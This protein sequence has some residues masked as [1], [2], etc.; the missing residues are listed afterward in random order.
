M[1]FRRLESFVP[2]MFSRA[3]PAPVQANP[4]E[5]A[6]LK[7]K[8]YSAGTTVGRTALG[9]IGN[10]GAKT[11]SQQK[12]HARPNTSAAATAHAVTSARDGAVVTRQ[13]VPTDSRVTAPSAG[14]F[15]EAAKSFSFV[16]RPENVADIDAGDI[17]NPQLVSEYVNECY[18]YMKELERRQNVQATYLSTQPRGEITPEMRRILIDW[19]VDVHVK[20]KLVQETMQMTVHVL[21]RFLQAVPVARRKLQLVGITCLLIASKYEDM[22][23]P[24]VADC[25]YVADNAYEAREVLQM[26]QLILRTL[27][28]NLG[29]PLALHFLRRYSK[30]SGTEPKVHTLAKYI[31]ELKMYEYGMAHIYP[32]ITAASALFLARRTLMSDMEWSST[33]E[34][35][36]GYNWKELSATVEDLE[37]VLA[38]AA[39]SKEQAVRRKFAAS[40][41]WRVS[42][43]EEIRDFTPVPRSHV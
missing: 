37:S 13:P 40:K 29:C 30:A 8:R 16:D 39:S 23:P 6:A 18:S 43:L 9:D 4:N 2:T 22:W 42:K 14:E 1:A 36:S 41:Y 25:V 24:R 7:A 3:A 27:D 5:N 26:E 34:Y 33:L 38:R 20:F 31:M 17:G 28:Y 11:K 10:G 15:A 12:A 21:D 32:S 35:Y 19:L